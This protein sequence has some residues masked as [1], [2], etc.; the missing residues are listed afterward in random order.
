MAIQHAVLQ[1]RVKKSLLTR[2]IAYSCIERGTD[3]ADVKWD[4]SFAQAFDMLQVGEVRNTRKS[5]L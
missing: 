4:F 1:A 2:P 5:P 3:D